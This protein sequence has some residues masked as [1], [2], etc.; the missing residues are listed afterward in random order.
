MLRPDL[1]TLIEI[2]AA[3]IE[4]VPP[5]NSDE[6]RAAFE[7]LTRCFADVTIPDLEATLADP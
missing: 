2:D 5:A 1:L 4:A 6:A 7:R 3:V